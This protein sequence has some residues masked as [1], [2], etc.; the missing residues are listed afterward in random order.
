MVGRGFIYWLFLRGFLK[1]PCRDLV[2]SIDGKAGVNTHHYD[3]RR[4]SVIV[5]SKHKYSELALA[6]FR[7]GTLHVH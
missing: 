5:T 3:C 6:F 7:C 4:V 1:V 2:F